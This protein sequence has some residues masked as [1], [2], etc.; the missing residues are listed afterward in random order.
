MTLRLGVIGLSEGNGHPY[1]WSAIFNGYDQRV[2]EDCGFPVIPRYLEKQNWPEAQIE[3]ADVTGIWSQDR[4]LSEHVAKAALIP[5]VCGGLEELRDVSD[6]ILLARDDAHNHIK[7]A[8]PF[9]KAGMPIYI[10]KPIALS[11]EDLEALYALEQ[12]PGQIFTCSA[13]RYSE[14]LQ[15]TPEDRE[16]IGKIQQ[17]TA[18]TPKSWAKYSMHMIEPVL[19]HLAP[20]DRPVSFNASTLRDMNNIARSLL[21]NWASGVQT[22]FHAT[23]IAA[24]PL[25]LRIH[26]SV[27]WQDLIFENTF[28]AFRAA[29]VDFTEGVTRHEVRSPRA[30]NERTVQIL[31]AGM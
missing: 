6:A 29:L 9:L 8:E 24:S 27:G 16:K 17:I 22:S 13:L 14:D 19:S 25:S 12:F 23:G 21:V 1:S 30:R 20:D 26:G 7:Y 5:N 10:D 28:Q 11:L 18:F 15:L 31:E 3:G 4:H 2:M